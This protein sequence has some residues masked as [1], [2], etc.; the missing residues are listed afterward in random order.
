MLEVVPFNLCTVSKLF[1]SP[2]EKNP[3]F[4]EFVVY[5]FVHSQPIY[6]PKEFPLK[7]AKNKKIFFAGKKP[8]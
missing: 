8:A 4:F 2:Y 3:F 7:L 6:L 1:S 5:V